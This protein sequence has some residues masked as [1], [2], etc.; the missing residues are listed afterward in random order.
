MISPKQERILAFA[1]SG[2]DALIADGA[3]RSGKTSLMAWAF[4]EWAMAGFENQR[5]GICAKT[6]G[7]AEQNIV[8]P[9]ISM[10][11]AR[12]RYSI[13]YHRAQ[14][15]MEV[16]RRGR[17]NIFEVF[18]GKDESSYALIQGRTLA[19]V[20]LDEV[21]LM[22]QS[23]VNQ[24]LARCSV[25]GAK[26]WFS[27][28]PADPQHWFYQS[29]ILRHEEHN[30][31]Y[32]RFAMTDNPSLSEKTL[33]RYRSMYPQGVFYDRY[34]LGKWVQAEGL[35]YPMWED[36]LMD[37]PPTSPPRR[38]VISLDYGTMNAFAALKWAEYDGFWLCEDEYYYSGRDEG[39]TK[40]DG[41]YAEDLERFADGI[42]KPIKVIIDP[43]AASFI[44]LLRKRGWKVI[45]ADNDVLDGI[46]ETATAFQAGKVKISRR[47][48]NFVSELQNYVWEEDAGEDRPV[49]ERDHACDAARYFVKTAEIMRPRKTYKPIFR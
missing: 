6:V 36:T 33:A 45:Q 35:I 43:S 37:A 28:N 46:R 32:L 5:F 26:L 47:C 11:L 24:A 40:T 25:D 2:Y 18:G 38:R 31:L 42:P 17:T 41:E 9:F 23:F 15:I 20:L 4:V 49:K 22:P 39:A 16:T 1:Q 3:V 21:V 14:K 48:E 44:A 19:G 27:C 30:A 8:V 7:S 12:E 10:G 34:V 13:K 29:W